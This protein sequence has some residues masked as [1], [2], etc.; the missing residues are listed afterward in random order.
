M[1]INDIKT[2]LTFTQV[3]ESAGPQACDLLFESAAEML[4]SLRTSYEN[5]KQPSEAFGQTWTP[6]HV[7][8]FCASLEKIDRVINKQISANALQQNLR[9][10]VFSVLSTSD[11]THDTAIQKIV[12]QSH[13]QEERINYWLDLINTGDTQLEG[14]LER[15]GRDIS[16]TVSL[17]RSK[18]AQNAPAAAARP[19]VDPTPTL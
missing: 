3:L 9:D 19:T 10:V 6:E 17:L 2:V 7:A 14:E 15:L 13:D 12:K 18:G 1:K 5:Q 11:F 4:R 16:A 8:K